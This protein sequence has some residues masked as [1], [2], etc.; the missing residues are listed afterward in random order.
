MNVTLDDVKKA[1]SDYKLANK[2]YTELTKDINPEISDADAKVIK[3]AS[4]YSKTYT[5]DSKG[6]RVEYTDEEKEKSK[7]K[8]KN[9]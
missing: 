8:C 7:K 4:I 5:L 3:V 2:V 6:N 9:S 1:Y